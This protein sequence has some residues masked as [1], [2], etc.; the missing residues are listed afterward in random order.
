ESS[1]I[2]EGEEFLLGF[3]SDILREFK[4]TVPSEND[5]NH[6]T[7]DKP[8]FLSMKQDDDI[9]QEELLN[10]NQIV[11]QGLIHELCVLISSEEILDKQDNVKIISF[12]VSLENM[13]LGSA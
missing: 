5:Q 6:V 1:V 13:I 10:K 11:E 8:D 9:I 4:K 2:P 12:C 3:M 7:L